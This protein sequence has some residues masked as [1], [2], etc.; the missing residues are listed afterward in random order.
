MYFD[1][2]T[3]H[4]TA[5]RRKMK[6]VWLALTRL[7]MRLG[8]MRLAWRLERIALWSFSLSKASS[9]TGAYQPGEESPDE[10]S[11]C[12]AGSFPRMKSGFE[13]DD[14]HQEL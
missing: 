5:K 4:N 9:P 7:I 10:H 12:P 6:G 2:E 14:S 11:L 8:L 1:R 3:Y 13:Q